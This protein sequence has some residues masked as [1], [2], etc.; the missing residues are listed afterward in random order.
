MSISYCNNENFE[1]AL[2]YIYK[3]LEIK[4][5]IV[6]E[7]HPDTALNNYLIG[8]FYNNKGNYDLAIDYRE[9]SYELHLKNS[10]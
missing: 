4:L 1:Y 5:K 8:R 7:N 6:S 10:R 3:C 2:E 9:K